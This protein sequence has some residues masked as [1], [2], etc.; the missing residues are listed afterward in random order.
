MFI[1][2]N[3][4]K[5]SMGVML[6]RKLIM[7]KSIAT[8]FILCFGF[9]IMLAQDYVGSDECMTCHNDKYTDWI[10]SGHPYKF[11]I[12][13]GGTPPTY[14]ALVTNFEDEWMD[15]LG[16]TWNDIAG[17]IGGFGWKARFV[18]LT[19]NLVGTANSSVNPGGGHNQFNFFA[20]D[21]YPMGNY[22]PSD[23]KI[24]NYDCF[25]CH[26]TGAVEG[27]D[28]STWLTGV[29][30]LGTF[31]EGGVGCE[32]CHGPGSDHISAPSTA[33]IDRVYE[34]DINYGNGLGGELPD[35]NGDDVI[36][37]CGTC[38]NRNFNATIEASGGYIKHHEPW[39]EFI[40]TEHY[41]NGMTC[42]TCHNP[43]K[44][45][46]WD[47]DAITMNCEICHTDEATTINHT[48]NAT[49]V[50]CHMPFAAKSAVARG[51]SG[52]KADIHSHLFDITVNTES[53]FTDDGSAVKDDSTRQASLD[54]GFTCLGCHNDD[55]LDIIPDKTLAEA[56]VSAE[57][58]HESIAIGPELAVPV[59]FLLKQNYPNP[60]N[61]T[62]I[63]PINVKSEGKVKVVLL[64]VLGQETGILM[65]KYVKPGQY[66]LVVNAKSLPSGV[67]YY[68]MIFESSEGTSYI[69]QK[70]MVVLK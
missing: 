69:D 7:K 17:V 70:K 15:S 18:D 30:S 53:M 64:N 11:S 10:D 13:E 16:A 47:G 58:M 25:R 32:G 45:T 44:R 61:P 26:T 37:L 1:G 23:V 42:T 38:H 43:H 54:L 22:H 46:I 56:A 24:Y 20:G 48:G 2:S 51:E 5:M 62:T 12:V 49:C 59:E 50:D 52:Y 6:R 27:T 35:P 39:E 66:E 67:Y 21:H 63:I 55:P 65:N 3:A 4:T 57:D 19:G 60:F 9:S 29:D 33:N 14:P 41:E 28:G 40:T 68:R 36:Y 34:Y 8:L 31:S